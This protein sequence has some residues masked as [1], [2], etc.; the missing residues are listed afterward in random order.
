[1][2]GCLYKSATRLHEA[3]VAWVRRVRQRPFTGQRRAPPFPLS[4]PMEGEPPVPFVLPGFSD[5]YET[6]IYF[7]TAEA[8]A[9]T[10]QRAEK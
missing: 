1:M 2:H 3:S 5:A 7:P 10:K 6:R 8:L 4:R 9:Y